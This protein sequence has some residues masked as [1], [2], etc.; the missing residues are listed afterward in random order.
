M[1]ESMC[2]G[3]DGAC[4]AEGGLG[5]GCGAI[6]DGVLITVVDGVSRMES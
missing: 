6:G 3:I 4:G 5:G 2:D 1:L